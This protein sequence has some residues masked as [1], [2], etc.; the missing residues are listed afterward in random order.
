MSGISIL[1][2]S[3]ICVRFDISGILRKNGAASD[4]GVQTDRNKNKTEA[5]AANSEELTTTVF[6]IL[7]RFLKCRIIS[8]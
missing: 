5:V 2:K 6:A 7:I 3:G 1:G 4:V 8:I